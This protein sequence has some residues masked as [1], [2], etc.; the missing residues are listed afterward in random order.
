VLSLSH[1]DTCLSGNLK[2]LNYNDYK[3]NGLKLIMLYSL[4]LV[5]HIIQVITIPN[6]KLKYR[7]MWWLQIYLNPVLC[8]AERFWACYIVGNNCNRCTTII[9]WCQ[10]SI[11]ETDDWESNFTSECTSWNKKGGYIMRNK[12]SACNG[13]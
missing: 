2:L 13:L 8:F 4:M 6:K 11:P 5:N 10:C 3:W 7:S 9:Q 12:I 1:E